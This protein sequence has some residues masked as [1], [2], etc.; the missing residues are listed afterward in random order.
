ME[1]TREVSNVSVQPVPFTKIEL[2]VPGCHTVAKPQILTWPTADVRM[3]CK[4]HPCS[5]ANSLYFVPVN[6]LITASQG[7]WKDSAILVYRT[8]VRTGGTF[9]YRI[10]ISYPTSLFSVC[11]E[12]RTTLAKQRIGR[13]QWERALIHLHEETGRAR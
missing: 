7:W 3:F 9:V 10:I 11:R 5:A 6:G 8:H 4:L 1:G 2:C 13:F 12:Q